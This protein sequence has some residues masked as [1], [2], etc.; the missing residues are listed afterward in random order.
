M[1]VARMNC[2]ENSMRSFIVAAALLPLV[3]AVHAQDLVY[4]VRSGETVSEG[5]YLSTDHCVSVGQYRTKVL[6]EPSH[7]KLVI[8]PETFVINEPPCKG[9]KFVGTRLSYTSAKGFRGTDHLSVSLGYPI[10]T[11]QMQYTY[12]TYDVTLNVR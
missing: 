5:V 10:D 12:K 6:K 4:N 8:R 11:S 3:T 9:R 1:R 7:G 2:V